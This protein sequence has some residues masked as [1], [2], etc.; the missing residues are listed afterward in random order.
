MN[1]K[2]NSH[3]N[4]LCHSII[5]FLLFFGVLS[6]SYANNPENIIENIAPLPKMEVTELH[7]FGYESSIAEMPIVVDHLSPS[8]TSSLTEL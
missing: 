1:T 2:I 3:S 6:G 5:Y 7:K 4:V 8:S